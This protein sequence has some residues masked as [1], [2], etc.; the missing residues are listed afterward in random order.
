MSSAK[1]LLLQ[2]QI[3]LIAVPVFITDECADGQ[4][5]I[6]AINSAHA[7]LTGLDKLLVR[8]RTPH[9]MIEDVSSATEVVGNY[10][11]CILADAPI[12]YRETI[13]FRG[14]PMVFDTT[15][16]KIPRPNSPRF[17]IVGTAI[18]I[19]DR[20]H[21]G[22]DINFYVS[23]ARNAMMTIEMLMNAR[24]GGDPMS[25]SEREATLIL[26]RKALL[27]LDDITSAADRIVRSDRSNDSVT[28]E[29]MRN[30]L[31]H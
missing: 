31:L 8:G 13:V 26:C 20:Q 29:A 17:R 18:K 12:S 30:I 5:R 15:L 19:E 6:A 23:L 24:S 7:K 16:Q 28:A 14:T 3:D 4:F 9:E 21:V 10:R 27:S 1:R 25:K 22:D 11:N 2:S